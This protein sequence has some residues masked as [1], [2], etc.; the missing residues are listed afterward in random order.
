MY[1]RF[2]SSILVIIS[3]TLTGCELFSQEPELLPLEIQQIQTREYSD[4]K[5]IVFPSVI[6]VFQDLGYT[7][8][9]ADKETGL[10]SAESVTKNSTDVFGLILNQTQSTS[11]TKATAFIETIGKITKVRLSFV[12]INKNSTETGQTSRNDTQILDVSIYQNAFER[13]ESAIFVRSSS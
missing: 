7:I 2:F 3:A 11:Q 9:S 1:Y 5:N 4:T 13:I 10:I 8:T 6:S 12:T